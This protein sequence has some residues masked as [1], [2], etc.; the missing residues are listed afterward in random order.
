MSRERVKEIFRNKFD[1]AYVVTRE[2]VDG[3]N[4]HYHMVWDTDK[5]K[6]AARKYVTRAL[7]VKGNAEYSLSEAKY[8][9]STL[10]YCLKGTESEPADIVCY[11]GL[12]LSPEKV[13]EYRRNYWDRQAKIA[14][15]KREI[16]RKYKK[17]DKFQD[18][19]LQMVLDQKLTTTHEVAELTINTLLEQGRILQDHYIRAVI[20][21]VMAKSSEKWKSNYICDIVRGLQHEEPWNLR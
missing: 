10:E 21:Y 6:D 2:T 7:G 8:V 16:R 13:E 18:Q 11:S 1:G 19:I 20:R 4:P 3:G 12:D 9:D 5:K 17:E 14:E 15:D